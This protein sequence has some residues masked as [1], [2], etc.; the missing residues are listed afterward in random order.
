MDSDL[1]LFV[2]KEKSP[3]MLSIY[4]I[5]QATKLYVDRTIQFVKKISIYVSYV[6]RRHWLP[7]SLATHDGKKDS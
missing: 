7:T 6:S 2:T 4:A 1:S 5:S 3:Q